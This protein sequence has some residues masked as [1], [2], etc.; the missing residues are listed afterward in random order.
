LRLNYSDID[1][2]TF[3]QEL[4]LTSP[5]G[6]A[7]EYTTG[8]LWFDNE[9]SE[10]YDRFIED[11]PAAIIAGTVAPGLIPSGFGD[12]LGGADAVNT[13]DTRDAVVETGNLGIFAEGTWHISD[14]WHLTAGARFIDEKTSIRLAT[15]SRLSDAA[16]GQTLQSSSFASPGTVS[17]TDSTVTGKL[18]LSHDWRDSVTVYGLFAT[19]YRGATF[20]LASADPAEALAN[21]VEPERATSYELGIKSR[22]FDDRL[23]VN[24]GLFLT[25]FR[26]FQAQI[27]DL[28]NA[29]SIVSHR[30]D[31]AGELQ[32]SGMELEFHA[33]PSEALSVV[34]AV[35]PA[36]RRGRRDRQRRRRRLRCAGR[37]RRRARQCTEVQRLA[38]H[39]LRP[40]PQ[41][42]LD[43]LRS[44]QRALADRSPVHERTTADDH[45][46]RLQH[47]GS[48][49]GLDR[50]RYTTGSR[51]LCEESLRAELRR[52]P[53]P[54]IP[55]Q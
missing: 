36:R 23:E 21:P 45:R 40:H 30:L 12:Q 33:R 22:L 52:Q 51:G 44:A 6:G 35:R 53:D 41:C 25:Y 8:F 11:I 34:G 37:L 2:E 27:R 9:I 18:A 50:R 15:T 20:D 49:S 5:G 29:G 42:R 1:L 39:P 19:G 26:D 14:T 43:S 17:V 10:D 24:G 7:L 48:A 31:N 28:Q 46:R 55:G 3:T 54:A 4:R 16:T 32:T 47:L 13:Y 38:H